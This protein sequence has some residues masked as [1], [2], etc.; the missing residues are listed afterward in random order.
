MR[1]FQGDFTGARSLSMK[2]AIRVTDEHN[3]PITEQQARNLIEMVC[4]RRKVKVPTLR[5]LTGR[6]FQRRRATYFG[7]RCQI[8]IYK[9]GRNRGTVLHELAHHIAPSGAKHGPAFARALEGLLTEF[10]G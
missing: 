4:E 10:E 5:W 8:V 3:Y 2:A 9:A 6:R 1:P 7:L